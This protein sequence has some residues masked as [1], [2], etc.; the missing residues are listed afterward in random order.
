MNAKALIVVL[1]AGCASTPPV[2]PGQVQAGWHGARY[3]TAVANWG[4]PN[5]STVL[6]DGRDVHT[7]VSESLTGGRWY[8]SIAFIGG[9][10]GMGMG[11]GA[12]MGAGG[13]ELLR[14]ER[15]L[16]FR[17]GRVVEQLWQGPPTYCSTF[18]RG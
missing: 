18:R 11:A 6:P 8:P 5:R 1:L 7:W 16:Y 10:R 4:A 12:T 17:D 14:C 15:T 13:G 2:D 9:S 3:E